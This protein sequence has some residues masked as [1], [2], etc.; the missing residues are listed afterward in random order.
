[1]LVKNNEK[2]KYN[3][4]TMIKLT[5][6]PPDFFPPS[7]DL[8]PY[9]LNI[10]YLHKPIQNDPTPAHQYKALC[11]QCGGSFFEI[12]PNQTD[13][14]K[15]LYNL[16]LDHCKFFFFLFSFFSFILFLCDCFF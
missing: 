1:M 11:D 7:E 2:M 3:L 12:N 8:F 16:K 15:A 13:F 9:T 14:H 10:L 6:Y 5:I 4:T